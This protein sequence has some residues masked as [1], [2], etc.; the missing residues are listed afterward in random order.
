M[1][2]WRDLI[3]HT[4]AKNG[5]SFDNLVSSVFD[6]DI[7]DEFYS[8]FGGHEGCAFQLWTKE[9]VYF[10]LVYDGAEWAGSAHRNPSGNPLAHDGGE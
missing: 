9:Y 5:D 6:G 7:D 4:M 10:P 8:G 1:S 2:T 3:Q